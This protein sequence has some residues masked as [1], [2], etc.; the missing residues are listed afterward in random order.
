MAIPLNIFGSCFDPKTGKAM[1][2][3]NKDC[4]YPIGVDPIWF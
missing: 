1:N 4:I 3:S 2:A